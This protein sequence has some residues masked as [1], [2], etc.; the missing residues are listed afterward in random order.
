MA[1]VFKVVKNPPQPCQVGA[2]PACPESTVLKPGTA[3]G[4]AGA[5]RDAVQAAPAPAGRAKVRTQGG[6]QQQAGVQQQQCGPLD[7]FLHASTGGALEQGARGGGCGPERVVSS[8]KQQAATNVAAQQSRN[9]TAITAAESSAHGIATG[10]TGVSAAAAIDWQRADRGG[11]QA[12]G[13]SSTQGQRGEGSVLVEPQGS[14]LPSS[15]ACTENQ[16]AH[17]GGGGEGSCPARCASALIQDGASVAGIA[18]A[19]EGMTFV[20]RLQARKQA[21]QRGLEQQLASSPAG[22]GGGDDAVLRDGARQKQQQQESSS[23][24][25]EAV[26]MMNLAEQRSSTLSPTGCPARAHQPA[27]PL[28]P[29]KRAPTDLR[30]PSKR[31]TTKEDHA[32][33]GSSQAGSARTGSARACLFG[34]GPQD[35]EDC[36]RVDLCQEAPHHGRPGLPAAAKRLGEQGLSMRQERV[37]HAHGR[38]QPD[39][40]RGV[41]E[42]IVISDSD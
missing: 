14:S 34:G 25:E 31:L 28:S 10:G 5:V 35:A 42:I 33:T 22:G 32:A 21:W 29:C 23:E 15:A 40:G 41:P 6:T 39:L 36:Q 24:A 37:R 12:V 27:S 9:H 18:Q 2:A 3:L 19:E 1:S 11:A 4:K 8:G 20:Q 7:R 17:N 38:S 26:A 13:R 16:V 30:S